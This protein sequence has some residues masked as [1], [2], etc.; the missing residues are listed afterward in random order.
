M[1]IKGKIALVTGASRGIGAAIAKCLAQAG[2][3]VVGTATT[4]EGV[5]KIEHE[6]AAFGGRAKCVELNQLDA[7]QKVLENIVQELGPIHILVNN[8][9]ITRD[10]VLVRMREEEW[11][12]VL[13]V[14]LKAVYRTCK[15]VLRGMMQAREGR[16]INLSSVVG[17]TG[18]TGQTN[19]AASKAGLVGFT[20][21]LAKEVGSRNITVNC[22]A[23][24]LIQTDMTASLSEASRREEILKHI[25]LRRIGQVEDI[26]HAVCFLASEEARYITGQTLHINGGLFMD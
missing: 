13:T 1:S 6:L 20:K 3:Q 21:S 16:I 8:A 25:P 19:Y 2:A 26:A 23:P 11:D 4:E 18:N 24:G 14:N 15:I 12:E 22:V 9:G 17:F 5:Q 10:N 7:S